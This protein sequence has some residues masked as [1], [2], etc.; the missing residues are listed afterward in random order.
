MWWNVQVIISFIGLGFYM[1]KWTSIIWM[2]IVAI[3]FSYKKF[4]AKNLS[5]ISLK[6]VWLLIILFT[7]FL[8]RF[9]LSKTSLAL[10]NPQDYPQLDFLERLS[11]GISFIVM[12]IIFYFFFLK[13]DE[14]KIK[15]H[16]L[17]IMGIIFLELVVSLYGLMSAG[18]KI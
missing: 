10:T 1:L 13:E 16:A 12:T 4:Y 6:N 7:T 11:F 17:W 9:S 15:I 3:Y 14:I 2:I 5:A 8:L 18:Y